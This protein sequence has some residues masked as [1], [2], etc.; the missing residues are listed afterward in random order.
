M[1]PI[2]PTPVSPWCP[3]CLEVRGVRV[4]MDG[5]ILSKATNA[6]DPGRV[7]TLS[8]ACGKCKFMMRERRSQRRSAGDRFAGH[9]WFEASG[10]IVVEDAWDHDL[11]LPEVILRAI[12]KNP[13]GFRIV[14]SDRVFHV[15][16]AVD[17]RP[18]EDPYIAFAPC[19]CGVPPKRQR[20]I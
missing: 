2:P 4:R 14:Y 5:P 16:A 18:R 11:L 15:S 8:F 1:E 13:E 6:Q 17:K 7:E 20:D 9:A 10:D 19:E 3:L 12:S